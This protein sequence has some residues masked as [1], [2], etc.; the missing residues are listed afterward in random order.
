VTNNNTVIVPLPPYSQDIAPNDF[1]LF[2]KLKIKL[3][4]GH[5]EVMPDIHRESQVVLD[6][7]KENDFHGPFEAWEKGW[8][9]C[10]CSQGDY[11]EGDGRQSPVS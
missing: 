3:K 11:F 1:T 9:C 10:T 8:D 7:T 2:P 4:E 5:F 6:N